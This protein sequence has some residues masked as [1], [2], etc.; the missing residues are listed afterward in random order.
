[1]LFWGWP[2]WKPAEVNNASQKMLY[3]SWTNLTVNHKKSSLS[4]DHFQESIA[5]LSI[6]RSEMLMEMIVIITNLVYTDTQKVPGA[7]FAFL[8]AKRSISSKEIWDLT[9]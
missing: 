6:F 7:Q 9:T 4:G 5:N 8:E 1:M 2:L 3:F